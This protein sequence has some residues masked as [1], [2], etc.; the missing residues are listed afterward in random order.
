[1][2]YR[3][4]PF[5]VGLAVVALALSLVVPTRPV[6]AQLQAPPDDPVTLTL[7]EAIQIARVH[8]YTV[9]STRL[10]V[11]NA[12]AQVREAWGQVMPQVDLTSSYTRNVVTANPFAGSEAGGLFSSFGFIDWLSFNE[13]AR[14]DDDPSTDPITFSEFVDRQRQ[15]MEEA[16]IQ[17]GGGDDNPFGVDNQ[18]QNGISISQ[19][20]YSGRAFAAIKG[21]Q[22]LKDINRRAADREEQLLIDQVRQAFYGAL[23]AQEQAR[24]VAQSVNRTRRTLEDVAQRVTQGVAPKFQRLSAEVEL[25]NLE[26]QLVQARNESDTALDNLKMTLGMPVEQPIRLRG[27]LSDD[28]VGTYLHVATNDAVDLALQQRPDL[29]QVRLAIELRR[30]DKDLTR[31]D[32]FPN[33]SA[34][35]NINYTGQVPDDRTITLSDPDDP[36]SFSTQSNSFFDSQY[37][38]PSVNVGLR[39]TWNLFNG[40]QTSSLMQQRQIAVE[41]AQVEAEQLAQSVRLEV[42]RALRDLKTAQQRIASQQQNVTRAELN[43]EHAQA[44][45]REGAATPLEEREASDQLDQSR[46]NY[47]QAVYDYLVARSA[48]ET[49]VGMPLARPDAV[50]LLLTGRP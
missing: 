3:E 13:Q 1:M 45:L 31:S 48:F 24:V 30:I 15:G 5:H 14:V 12:S 26:T 34:F 18:F 44:R 38:N 4:H 36:F 19:T 17:P 7:D 23:L 11:E 43:Y 40:F 37:W 35:A 21:A 47:L 29:E 50:N 49:A 27:E 10:D 22:Y 16:G 32:Y 33:V 9:R 28:Q 20:I 25:A 46:L 6:T 41:K 2:K 8:N 39:L 42:E